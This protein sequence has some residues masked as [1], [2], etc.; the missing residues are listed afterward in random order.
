M[1]GKLERL[2]V[3]E[4]NDSINGIYIVQ[5]GAIPIRAD[6]MADDA[7]LS[8]HGVIVT[9]GTLNAGSMYMSL[10]TPV[11]GAIGAGTQEWLRLPDPG[12]N[13]P[14]DVDPQLLLGLTG[15]PGVSDDYSRGDHVHAAVLV[16]Q[17]GGSADQFI[18]YRPSAI[19]TYYPWEVRFDATGFTY[20]KWLNS[21]SQGVYLRGPLT[22]ASTPNRSK[23]QLV[24]VGS[25]DAILDIET[26]GSITRGSDTALWDSDIDVTVAAEDHTHYTTLIL[27][28]DFPSTSETVATVTDLQTLTLAAG[29]YLFEAFLPIDTAAT[30]TGV[31][32]KFNV[33]PTATYISTNWRIPI[34]NTAEEVFFFS[35][36]S[37]AISTGFDTGGPRLATMA[38][39]VV[40]TAS[41]TF[42]IQFATDVAAS[43]TTISA[44]ASMRVTHIA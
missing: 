25:D 32:L 12:S 30:T 14:S 1:N 13:V 2:L 40:S 17:D 41:G 18:A 31:K 24:S 36:E 21:S 10:G 26:G 22:G 9:D 39:T 37:T 3:K 11:S 27:T 28:S 43:T 7:P 4:G 15:D 44:G 5:T 8:G 23:L 19:T 35:A 20:V 38:A 6:D 29:T 16:Q 42:A 33:G 34:S